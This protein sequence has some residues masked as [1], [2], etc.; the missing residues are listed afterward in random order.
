ME[1]RI[2]ITIDEKGETSIDLQ[3]FKGKGCSK[4]MADF[5]DGVGEIKEFRRKRE[6]NEGE[7]TSTERRRQTI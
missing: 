6:Y 3:N 2:E 1:K 7:E 5:T 4:V